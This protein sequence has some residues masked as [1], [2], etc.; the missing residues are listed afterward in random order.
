ME[1]L[2]KCSTEKN[3]FIAAGVGILNVVILSIVTMCITVNS[4]LNGNVALSVFISLFYGFIMFIG[5]WGILSVI[6]KTVKYTIGVKTFSFAASIILVS[7]VSSYALERYIIKNYIMFRTLPVQ[8]EA[9]QS[10]F[11]AIVVFLVVVVIYII[12][13]VLK[14]L[15]NSSTYE[16]EKERMEHNFIIQKEADMVAYREKYKNYAGVFT[17]AN[18]KMESI[19]QLGVLTQEYHSLLEK[20][21]KET[22]DFINKIEKSNTNDNVLLNEVKLKTEEE[23]KNTISKMADIFGSVYK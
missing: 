19:K 20:I 3:G 11:S 22:F 7:L 10:Y 8:N 15:I 2:Q 21:Q 4:V 23:F 17:D 16:E 5:Y 1:I 14:L 9:L 12:P 18:I 6:R 13:I